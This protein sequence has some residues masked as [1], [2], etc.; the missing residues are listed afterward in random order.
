MRQLNIAIVT[1]DTAVAIG[2]KSLIR[3]LFDINASWI[4][5][6]DKLAEQPDH[7]DLYIVDAESFAAYPVFFI[8]RRV[9]VAVMGNYENAGFELSLSRSCSEANFIRRLS[10]ILEKIRDK[11]ADATELTQREIDVLRLV[12]KGY[13]NKEIAE[14]LFIS[15]NTVLSHRKNISAKLGIRSVSGLSVYAM[16]NGYIG[17]NPHEIK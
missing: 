17:E 5:E 11:H 4:R 14:H 3:E 15:T 2:L 12:A 7:T 8:P 9:K 16:M 6:C 10:D 1:R 13:T